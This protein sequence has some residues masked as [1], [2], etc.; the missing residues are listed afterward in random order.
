[1]A[2]SSISRSRATDSTSG[3]QSPGDEIAEARR[4]AYIGFLHRHPFAT[5][6]YE[7]GFTVGIREDCSFQADGLRNVDLPIGILD[8]DFKRP[9]LDR[10]L[11]RFRRIEPEIGV[12]GDAS[13][14]AEANELVKAAQTLREEYPEA[15]LIIVPKC[16][17]AIDIIATANSS[18]SP[19]VLGYSMGYSDVLAAD[20]SDIADWRGHPVH[21]LGAS[22]PK[23]WDVIQALTQP[24]L[25]DA[26]PANI[27]GLDWNGPQKVAYNGEYWSREGWKG[28]DLETIRA[29]VRM[30]LREMRAFWIDRDVWPRCGIPVDTSGPAVRRPDDD[31]WAGSGESIH[32]TDEWAEDIEQRDLDE[33]L[34]VEGAIVV[35]YEDGRT[36]AYRSQAE[37]DHVEYYEGIWNS[38]V[39]ETRKISA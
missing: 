32:E 26:P 23:Q 21:L 37:R 33:V 1:M 29:T 5:D 10:Y 7:L 12:I 27:V 11:E 39:D 3:V 17:A 19:F 28:A 36:L 4:A 8:N 24:T 25:T 2:D 14:P 13:A 35:T 31:C 38:V 9:D 30:S 15:T 18:G 22:P 6:A 34:P 16:R 20:F